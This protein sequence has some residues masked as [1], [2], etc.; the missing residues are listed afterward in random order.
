MPDDP[1]ATV[2]SPHAAAPL[3]PYPP[4]APFPPYPP[5]PPVV[6][7]CC[8]GSGGCGGQHGGQTPPAYAAPPAY[9]A[10][11]PYVPPG[12]LPPPVPP[13]GIQ[14]DPTG[15]GGA[16]P[17]T[18]PGPATGGGPRPGAGGFNPFDPL[19]SFLNMFGLP[20]PPDPVSGLLGSLFGRTR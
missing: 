16:H 1:T 7:H 3:P 4:Y 17:A 5:Y 8:Q 14:W 2:V 13:P 19:G 12:Q 11:P 18:P 15:T 6:I 9:G 10:P 20:A